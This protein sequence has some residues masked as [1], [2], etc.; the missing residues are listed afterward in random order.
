MIQS[1]SKNIIV[2]DSSKA[3]NCLTVL[4]FITFAICISP[5]D[6]VNNPKQQN[7]HAAG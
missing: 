3:K 7:K 4:L 2:T 5:A 1:L 6:S